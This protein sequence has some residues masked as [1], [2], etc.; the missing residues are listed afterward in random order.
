M[1]LIRGLWQR[2]LELIDAQPIEMGWHFC[3]KCGE[4]FDGIHACVHQTVGWCADCRRNRLLSMFGNCEACGSTA[5][6]DRTFLH[7]ESQGELDAPLVFHH[8]KR[9]GLKAK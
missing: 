2:F 8:S 7:A 5:V 6:T 1:T 3:R 4:V 9:R